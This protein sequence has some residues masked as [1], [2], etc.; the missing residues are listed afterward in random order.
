M[1]KNISFFRFMCGM[2][3]YTVVPSIC[4]LPA[5]TLRPPFISFRCRVVLLRAGLIII[6][7]SAMYTM[8]FHLQFVFKKYSK[9]W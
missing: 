9:S 2:N 6:T 7:I 5:L 1:R 3:L 4:L 8:S